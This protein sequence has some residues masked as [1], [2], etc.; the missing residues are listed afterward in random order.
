MS[1]IE[2]QVEPAGNTKSAGR[3]AQDVQQYRWCFTLK[4]EEVQ[5]SQLYQTLKEVAKE[6][7]FQTE[8]S[9]SGYIHYQGV[10]SLIKKE[11]LAP[12][13]N[14]LGYNTIHL[15]RCQNWHASKRYCSKPE[16]RIDG[17]WTD[18]M[19]P[20]KIIS[21]LYPWQEELKDILLSEPND[22]TIYWIYEHVGN[23][24][25]SAFCKYMVVKHGATYVRSG[26]NADISYALPDHPTM[27]LIDIPRSKNQH[28]NFDIIEQIKDGMV[29][30]PKYESKTKMFDPPHIMVF[31]NEE[32]DEE[33]MS[34][35]RWVIKHI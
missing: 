18:K 14:N 2:S 35:D 20:L 23:R 16:S 26:K 1:E 22:R 31:S 7:V 27:V 17:P 24:G 32:P 29:F 6:F 28:V 9:E 21:K 34:K 4:A 5:V 25:K 30:S 12:L 19:A 8:K 15:E 3:K 10:L 13:K 33:K 11:R